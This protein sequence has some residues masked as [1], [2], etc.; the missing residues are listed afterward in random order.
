MDISDK[1]VGFLSVKK[2]NIV[3]VSGSFWWVLN[4]YLQKNISMYTAVKLLH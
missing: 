4:T 3:N 2:E 1:N